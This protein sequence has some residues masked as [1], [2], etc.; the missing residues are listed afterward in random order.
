MVADKP[1]EVRSSVVAKKSSANKV[2]ESGDAAVCNT[3]GVLEIAMQSDVIK[4]TV[5]HN[6]IVFFL[7]SFIF[8]IKRQL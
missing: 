7:L 6:D 8:I 1:A 3:D 2:Q 4:P 5:F